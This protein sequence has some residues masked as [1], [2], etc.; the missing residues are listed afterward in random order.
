MRTEIKN[1]GGGSKPHWYP[2]VRFVTRRLS[3]KAK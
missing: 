3:L 1:F 2:D